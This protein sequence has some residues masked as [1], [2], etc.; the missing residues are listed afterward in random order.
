MSD[1][2]KLLQYLE[3]C[4][5]EDDFDDIFIGYV[6][7]NKEVIPASSI[8]TL[9]Q[10]LSGILNPKV[11]RLEITQ[12]ICYERGVY[13]RDYLEGKTWTNEEDAKKNIQP[14]IDNARKIIDACKRK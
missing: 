11:N 13:L 5:D 1:K 8:V 7:D 4:S 2:N 12:M 6:L 10:N 9:I 3:R 14:Q